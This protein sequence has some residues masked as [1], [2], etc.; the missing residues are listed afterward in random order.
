MFLAIIND[1]YADVKAEI[2][3]APNKDSPAVT[4]FAKN[5]M[6]NR[7]GFFRRL[8]RKKPPKTVVEDDYNPNI[9]KIKE[10]LKE[11]ELNF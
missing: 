2:A 10:V 7:I 1:T 9:I 4:D 8:F 5:L 6:K 11:Y 3:A